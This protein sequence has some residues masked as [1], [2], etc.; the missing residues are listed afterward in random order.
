[1]PQGST[2]NLQNLKSQNLQIKDFI[3]ERERRE[4]TLVFDILGQTVAIRAQSKPS[5]TEILTFSSAQLLLR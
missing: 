3:S 1:M 4:W 2:Q 5:E